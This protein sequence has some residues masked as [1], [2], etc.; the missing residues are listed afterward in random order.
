MRCPVCKAD[1]SEGPQC[2]RCK[3]DLQPLFALEEHRRQEMAAAQRALVEGRWRDAL[4]HA[5]RADSLQSDTESRRLLAVAS[6]VS[7]DYATALR[8]YR[9]ATA[10]PDT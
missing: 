6:L 4:R 10:G 5:V 3:V 2:R 7:H 8:V 9:L 1:N